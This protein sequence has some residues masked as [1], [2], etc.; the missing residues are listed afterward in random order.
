MKKVI[1]IVV[2][3][4]VLAGAFVG[5][6]IGGVIKVPGLTP[7]KPKTAAMYGESASKLYVQPKEEAPI[8]KAPVK[9]P[10]LKPVV[11]TVKTDPELGSKKLAQLWNSLPTPKLVELAKFS[12]DTELAEV[13]IKMDPEKVAELLGALDANR[14]AKLSKELRRVA[15][16]V[17]K[18]AS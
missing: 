16:I 3:I 5:L 18:A 14:S 7:K 15:S 11:E 4:I 13:L 17:P 10:V 1:M 8:V 6:A 2:P 9:K 12:K